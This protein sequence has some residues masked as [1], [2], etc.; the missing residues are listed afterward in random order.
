MKEITEASASVGLLLAT[1]VTAKKQQN[2]TEALTPF[3]KFN[4]FPLDLRLLYHNSLDLWYNEDP[5][6]SK[7]SEVKTRTTKNRKWCHVF[8][9]L[10][11]I[12]FRL[13]TY[14]EPPSIFLGNVSF[15]NFELGGSFSCVH[16]CVVRATLASIFH[17]EVDFT[18]TVA[19][20]FHFCS[21]QLANF[22][23]PYEVSWVWLGF[24]SED[25]VLYHL[26]LPCLESW[27]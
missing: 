22:C 17:T 19:K 1:V 5:P 6:K 24:T 16:V 26:V 2:N 15:W 18:L 23:L 8:H 27:T 25:F 3:A 11:I 9:D 4:Y 12:H 14:V 13:L 10:F 7:A 20:Y 21:F